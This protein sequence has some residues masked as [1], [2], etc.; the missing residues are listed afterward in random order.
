MLNIIDIASH[1]K[2]LNVNQ[3]VCD[4]VIVKATEGVSYTNPLF[5]NQCEQTQTSGKVLGLYH[6]AKGTYTPEQEADHFLSKVADYIGLVPL[7]LDFEEQS[8]LTSSGVKWVKSWLDYVYK[9]T[10]VRPMIY[11]SL[12]TENQLPWSTVVAANY[13]LWLAQYNRESV[14]TGFKPRALFGVLKHWPS[15]AMFQY[16]N[17]GR[18]AGWSAN[19]DFDIFY[20]DAKAWSAYAQ[21]VSEM[22]ASVWIDKSGIFT[23]GSGKKINL[24]AAPNTTAKIIAIMGSGAR[25][26]YQ[27]YASIGGYVWI[28]QQR[29]DGSYGYLATGTAS[30]TTQTSSWG[31]GI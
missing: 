29:S 1:Q 8:L 15:M 18:L 11:M 31:S 28:R 10:G 4:G 3:I 17:C 5:M 26:K 24:R 7:F 27:A 6:Y 12:S 23:V 22:K 2:G 13:G 25:I 19:L 30:G 14:V 20:G 9:Q 21:P 16:T